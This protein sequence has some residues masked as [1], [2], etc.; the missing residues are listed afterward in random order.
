MENYQEEFLDYLLLYSGDYLC[1]LS[2][3]EFIEFRDNYIADIKE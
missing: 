3:K 2:F 1:I